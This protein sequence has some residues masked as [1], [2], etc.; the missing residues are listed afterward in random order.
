MVECRCLT[1]FEG[2]FYIVNVTINVDTDVVTMLSATV[3][4]AVADAGKGL[5][6]PGSP[7]KALKNAI[8]LY[9]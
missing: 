3:F 4:V 2:T 5:T 9:N 6:G 8:F 7:L 1:F